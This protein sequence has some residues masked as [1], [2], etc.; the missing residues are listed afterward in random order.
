[1]SL[2]ASEFVMATASDAAIDEKVVGVFSVHVRF[3]NITRGYFPDQA[4]WI[5]DLFDYVQYALI[6]GQNVTD[7]NE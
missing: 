3:R 4:T 5:L 7:H 6:S 2:A 1:M